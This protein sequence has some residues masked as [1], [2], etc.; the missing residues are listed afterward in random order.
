MR[1]LNPPNR[2]VFLFGCF[3]SALEAFALS[4]LFIFNFILDLVLQLLKVNPAFNV[5]S[6]SM[7]SN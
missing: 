5:R 6:A 4:L 2:T 1:L 3:Y 7:L